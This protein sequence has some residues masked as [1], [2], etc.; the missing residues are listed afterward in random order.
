MRSTPT[1]LMPM[2]LDPD[3]MSLVLELVAPLLLPG[4]S[5]DF[6]DRSA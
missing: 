5:L 2:M 1:R 4:S 3:A 6:G